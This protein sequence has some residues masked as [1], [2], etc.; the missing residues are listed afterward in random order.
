MPG[1]LADS[2]SG[3]FARESRVVHALAPHYAALR[4][5]R[6][7]RALLGSELYQRIAPELEQILCAVE[8]GEHGG[9]R[10]R[11][12]AGLRAVA[13]NIQRGR[14]FEAVRDALATDPVLA[15]A[16]V[17][18]LSEVD[19]GMGR[20]G[21]RA[22]ARELALARGMSYAFGV[23]YLV[24]EDDYGENPTR[25]ANT[26]ALAGA[27]ILSRAPIA[28]VENV[29]LPELR[30]KFSSLE[31]RLGKKRA[32]LAELTLTD[33]PL[34]VAVC[35]LDSNASP[36]QRAAQLAAL[37]ER[38]DAFGG[39]RLLLGG[40]LNTTTYDLQSPLRL[41]VNVLDKLLVVGFAG[42]IDHYMKPE[43]RYERPI[44]ELLSRRGYAVD[45][46]NDRAV[47]TIRYDLD[48]AYA[49]Q[50]TARN[51]GWPLTWL[52]RRLLR[53]W[54]GVVPARLDWFAGRG[55]AATDARVV[56]PRSE[57]GRPASDH[58]AIVTD[59]G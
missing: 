46:F 25:A 42:A 56:D 22:V 53:P 55:L 6:S 27:A 35:H 13:W 51:I 39:P 3:G 16:D 50:K 41:A 12:L 24:L 37:L 52:L 48:D 47:G 8:V 2:L 45:P 54:G 14:R 21:N 33:G 11:P 19:S 29:D 30:D 44:F 9:A 23:S 7:R 36:R 4:A 26:Q 17:V 49:I 20:S 5:V 59:L 18:C 31:R 38:A 10:P 57:D 40:D 28:R 32:L 1:S 43:L 15:A 58:A 34:T